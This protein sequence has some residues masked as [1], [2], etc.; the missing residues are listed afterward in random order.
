M[1]DDAWCGRDGL[2]DVDG[3]FSSSTG[4]VGLC[5][6]SPAGVVGT[7]S[8]V[9]LGNTAGSVAVTDEP[10]SDTM[11]GLFCRSEPGATWKGLV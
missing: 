5:F 6:S 9:E 7:D 1:G 10:E 2:L 8:A 3:R 4:D 11:I